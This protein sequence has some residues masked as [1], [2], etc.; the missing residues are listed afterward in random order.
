[1]TDWRDAFSGIE[2]LKVFFASQYQMV[3]QQEK[4]APKPDKHFV[5]AAPAQSVMVVTA[6]ASKYNKFRA[7]YSP[8]IGY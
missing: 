4:D 3:S 6:P 1:M 2:S 8:I 5:D 7:M